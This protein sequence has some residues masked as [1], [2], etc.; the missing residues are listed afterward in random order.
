MLL[1]SCSKDPDAPEI[2]T[3]PNKSIADSAWSYNLKV[4]GVTFE[5]KEGIQFDGYATQFD[6]HPSNDTTKR[7]F[8][9]ALIGDN[10]N[11][12]FSF[13]FQLGSLIFSEDSVNSN[14][15]KNFVQTG[16]YSYSEHALNGVRLYFTDSLGSVWASDEGIQDQ[17]GSNFNIT[18]VLPLGFISGN[19]TLKFYATF[20]CKLYNSISGQALTVTDGTYIGIIINHN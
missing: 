4:N 2:T 18:D 17:T 10:S 20:N 19:Y 8:I 12:A 9:S 11:S 3:T 6:T 1:L 14:Q 15:F 5:G 16:S 7:M 13:S